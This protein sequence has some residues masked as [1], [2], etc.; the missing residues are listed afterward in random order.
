MFLNL[1]RQER[2]V[3]LKTELP[4]NLLRSQGLFISKVPLQPPLTNPRSPFTL[5]PS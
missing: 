3:I 4:E 1:P 2:K 5:W